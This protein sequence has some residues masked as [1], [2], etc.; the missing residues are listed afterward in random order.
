[1]LV[2]DIVEKQHDVISYKKQLRNLLLKTKSF[3]PVRISQV[4]GRNAK[5]ISD[6]SG[7]SIRLEYHATSRK[8]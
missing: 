3:V 6:S 8:C 7:H 5:S 4:P 1:M 2:E